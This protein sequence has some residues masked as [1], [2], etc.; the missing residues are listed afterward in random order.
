MCKIFNVQ[1]QFYS[2]FQTWKFL[3]IFARFV[4]GFVE[5]AQT[6]ACVYAPKRPCKSGCNSPIPKRGVTHLSETQFAVVA[7][8]THPQRIS[9]PVERALH[10][11][12][13]MDIAARLADRISETHTLEQ[14]QVE[15]TFYDFLELDVVHCFFG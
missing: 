13:P 1:S 8:T 5:A 6:V 4:V 12:I 2:H 10:T 11:Q 3:E 7:R 15:A 14:L 9:L